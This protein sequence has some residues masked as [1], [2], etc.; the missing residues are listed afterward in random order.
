MHTAGDGT[1][2]IYDLLNVPQYFLSW[3]MLN[4]LKVEESHTE[5][6]ALTTL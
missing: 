3:K 4:I 6:L 2:I 1:L 5:E